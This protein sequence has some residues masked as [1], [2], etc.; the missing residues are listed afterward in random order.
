MLDEM[1]LYPSGLHRARDTRGMH[2]SLT[3]VREP[4]T[5]DAAL[6]V[7]AAAAHATEA[8]PNGFDSADFEGVEPA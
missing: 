1:W 6:Q 4:N 2:R 8:I 3:A 7:F 5:P